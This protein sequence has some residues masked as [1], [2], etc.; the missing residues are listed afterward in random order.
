MICGPTSGDRGLKRVFAAVKP[1][2]R[3]FQLISDQAVALRRRRL[4]HSVGARGHS[5]EHACGALQPRAGFG[6]AGGA[7]TRHG[8][9]HHGHRRDQQP[10]Q[11][12]AA[13][14]TVPPPRRVRSPRH[15]RRAV[16]PVPAR[17]RHRAPVPRRRRAGDDRRF[18]R[19]R[20]PRH[21]A[22][23]AGRPQ[24]RA[25]HGRQPVRRRA[26]RAHGRDPAATPR[27]GRCSRSTTT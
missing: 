14:V 10:G 1:R 16:E 15:R 25:R 5:V 6:R 21:A 24:G 20:L 12:P 23:A 2:Q 26:R 4:R 11:N 19:L 18:S 22:G 17:A 9:R 27:T 3:R 7:R 13:A 8:D